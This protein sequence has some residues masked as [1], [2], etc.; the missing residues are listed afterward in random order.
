MTVLS[1]E[2]EAELYEALSIHLYQRHCKA[3]V[4]TELNTG[5]RAREIFALRKE[6]VDLRKGVIHFIHTKHW[7]ARDIPMNELLTKVLKEAISKYPERPYVFV[8][9]KNRET[10]YQYQDEFRQGKRL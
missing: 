9:P 3:I 8:N 2:K 1:W 7:E 4:V 6:N 5:M 10:V